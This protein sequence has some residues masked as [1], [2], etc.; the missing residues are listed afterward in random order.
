M[1]LIADDLPDTSAAAQSDYRC[2]IILSR[3]A[4]RRRATLRRHDLPPRRQPYFAIITLRLFRREALLCYAREDYV[5]AQDKRI[6]VIL[7][8]VLQHMAYKAARW[9]DSY[10]ATSPPRV[11]AVYSGKQSACRRW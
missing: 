6:C 2:R 11:T 8:K 9:R 1:R 5:A 3:V 7:M 4:A 10:A